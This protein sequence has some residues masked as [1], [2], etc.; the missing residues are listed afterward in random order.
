MVNLSNENE[1]PRQIAG[2]RNDVPGQR[3][4]YL[5][6]GQQTIAIVP[7]VI[8]EQNKSVTIPLGTSSR[9]NMWTKH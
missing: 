5:F 1:L 8:S 6:V 3:H 7:K 4:R 2:V 9:F